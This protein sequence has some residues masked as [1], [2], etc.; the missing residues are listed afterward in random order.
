MARR[1]VRQR[2]EPGA[3]DRPDLATEVDEHRDL[4]ADLHNGGVRRT[5][6]L[7]AEQLTDDEQ[8]RRGGDRQELGDPLHH[9]QDEGLEPAHYEPRP[10]ESRMSRMA[11]NIATRCSR[12]PCDA[13][14]V[15]VVTPASE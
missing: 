5:G 10:D 11:R 3:D 15:R 13:L 1:F 2:T 8:V 12:V 14:M 6:V 9:T 7:P 4:G